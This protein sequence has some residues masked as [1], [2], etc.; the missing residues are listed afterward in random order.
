[1]EFEF[2]RRREDCQ[3]RGDLSSTEVLERMSALR[4]LASKAK[5][6]TGREKRG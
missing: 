5:V 6:G 1:M 4:Q 2:R 3:A